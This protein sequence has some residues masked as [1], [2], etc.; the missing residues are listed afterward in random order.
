M[1][2][3]TRRKSLS[4]PSLGIH[5]PIT[6]AA[7]AAAAAA[8]RASSSSNNSSSARANSRANSP[9][10]MASPASTPR[11]TPPPQSRK[12][13]RAHPDDPEDAA[14]SSEPLPK[15]RDES[16]VRFENTPPPSPRS[17]RRSVEMDDV[18]TAPS[19]A[20]DMDSIKDEI[21]EAVIVQLQKTANRPHLVKE[22]EA[23]LMHQL[24]I[25][26]QSANPCAIISSRLASYLKRP[27]WSA[28]SPCPLAKELESVHPR[29]TYFYLTTCPHLPLPDPAHAAALSQLAHSR[30]ITTPDLS[31]ASSS[32]EADLE[33]RRELSP[34]PEVDLSS[35]EFDD[36]DDEVAM[37]TTPIG[38][39]SL[40]G[41]R[42]HMSRTHHNGRRGVSPP[43]EKDE[44]EFTQTAD[45]LQKRK[46]KGDLFSVITSPAGNTETDY[47][48]KDDNGLFGEKTLM[49]GLQ[50]ISFVT[51]PA[52]RPSSMSLNFAK[53]DVEAENWLKLDGFLEWDRSP[54][55]IALEELDGLLDDY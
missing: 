12:L 22:L 3:N 8:N 38:S 20:I 53:R 14:Q 6:H 5:V 7:R 42:S 48:Q 31:S 11:A 50:P 54:E 32:D 25:V 19:K 35:P 28:K 23:V 44:K 34:S 26:Q 47:F 49:A 17:A 1:P 52:I 46:L 9:A 13:K 27:C 55:N 4:L 10:S 16:K 2:Y 29:R 37:P 24:K 40:R 33:R 39:L 41:F 45:G 43:L 18:D 21:V 51:S 30:T 15:R 36:M